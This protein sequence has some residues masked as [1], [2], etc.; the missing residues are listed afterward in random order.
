VSKVYKLELTDKVP[1][2]M[3]EADLAR[4][5]IQVKDF[6]TDEP[7]YEIYT[8]G[9][10]TVVIPVQGRESGS[11]LEQFAARQLEHE[12]SQ[13]VDNP[14]VEFESEDHVTLYVDEED[15]PQLIGKEGENID[16]V[17]DEVGIDITVE[18]REARDSSM[19]EVEVEFH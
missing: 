16:R 1:T 17:E 19:E 7:E 4:P 14:T 3:T 13:Y 15:I 8:Y 18:S 9:E 10:E 6:E 5:V 2:G 12:L 11:K